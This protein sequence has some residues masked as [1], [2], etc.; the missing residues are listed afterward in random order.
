MSDHYHFDTQTYE[1]VKTHFKKS[2][3]HVIA[4]GHNVKEFTDFALHKFDESYIPHL[5]QFLSDVSKGDIKIKGLT[6]TAKTAIIGQH[7]SLRERERMIREAAYYLAEKRGFTVGHE[8]DDWSEAEREV[9]TR[10]A[11]EAGLIEMG[12]KLAVSTA[13]SVEKEFGNVKDLVVEWLE[14]RHVL[15]VEGTGAK[16][17]SRSK[18]SASKELGR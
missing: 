2:L 16:K 1:A 13:T 12:R 7:V 4:A 5:R 17:K 15:P 10:L 6:K 14:T 11:E 8:M 18:K 3:E 9:D